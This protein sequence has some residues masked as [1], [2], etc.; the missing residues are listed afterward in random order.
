MAEQLPPDS[1]VRLLRAKNAHLEYLA[2]DYLTRH[3]TPIAHSPG[4][5]DEMLGMLLAEVA[6]IAHLLADHIEMRSGLAH[7][8]VHKPYFDRPN[9]TWGPESPGYDEMGQ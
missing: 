6:L 5:V 8:T 3:Q 9:A 4:I 1:V 7:D 2:K